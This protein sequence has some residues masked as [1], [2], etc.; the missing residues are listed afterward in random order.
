MKR[1]ISLIVIGG[2]VLSLCSCDSEEQD[3]SS[4][5]ERETEVEETE[6]KE[7]LYES[8]R[9]YTESVYS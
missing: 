6:V 3:R 7:S 8:I 1:L 9:K 5:T 4:Q 2:L